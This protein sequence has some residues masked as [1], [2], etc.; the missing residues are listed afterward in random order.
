[1]LFD[2][3]RGLL[4]YN[5]VLLVVFLGIPA[6]YKRHKESLVYAVVTLFPS[7]ALLSV[8]NE[9]QGGDAPTGRY[10]MA[11]VPVFMPALAFVLPL[12]R[13]WWQKSIVLV[14]GL[15]T[16]TISILASLMKLDYPGL[17]TTSEFFSK[18]KD[19][20]GLNLG[21]PFPSYSLKT[22]F[23]DRFGFLEAFCLS[24]LL[25]LIVVYGYY[26][27]LLKTNRRIK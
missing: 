18:L 25:I 9:W 23:N 27:T 15:I 13:Q 7:M 16:F 1:M 21:S 5:P 20:T 14:L 17:R 24:M 4:V 26:L 22:T 3:Q 19:Y 10:L 6:W 2:E 12:L 11:F 8:F